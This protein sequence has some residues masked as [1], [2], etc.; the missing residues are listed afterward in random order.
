MRPGKVE[1]KR[2][3]FFFFSPIKRPDNTQYKRSTTLESLLKSLNVTLLGQ[4]E[5]VKVDLSYFR[6]Y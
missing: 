4:L 2:W 3:Y 6:D 1:V 5:V